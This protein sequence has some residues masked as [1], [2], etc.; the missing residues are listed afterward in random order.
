MA[1]A[2]TPPVASAPAWHYRWRRSGG[3][4]F[5]REQITTMTAPRRLSEHDMALQD[6]PEYSAVREAF[7][8][9]SWLARHVDQTVGSSTTR[10]K[11][12]LDREL[13]GLLDAMV[14]ASPTFEI[15]PPTF[16]SGVQSLGARLMSREVE[17]TAGVVL[18]G[19]ALQASLDLDAGLQARQLTEDEMSFLLDLGLVPGHAQSGGWNVREV[20]QF[21]LCE[22]H[23]EGKIFGHEPVTPPPRRD[24]DDC[25]RRL[26]TALRLVVGGCVDQGAVFSIHDPWRSPPT[27]GSFTNRRL[28]AG[29]GRPS[30]IGPGHVSGVVGYYRLLD[31]PA[32]R[33]PRSLGL[34]L[35]RFAD[36]PLRPYAEDALIDLMI[37]ADGLFSGSKEFG[38]KKRVARHA[39]ERCTLTDASPEEVYE[40]MIHAYNARSELVHGSGQELTLRDIHGQEATIDQVVDDLERIVQLGLLK[41]IEK[42]AGM[43]P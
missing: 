12:D 34:L 4:Y 20:D 14:A 9:D 26:R 22:R 21:A 28:V 30:V 35:R 10:S 19:L 31:H 33:K 39:S 37:A 8:A 7:L 25:A 29:G 41:A 18:S 38:I 13:D 36:S 1:A 16:D 40:F 2:G 27:S 42:H 17:A 11:L 23:V 3:A 15:D 6:M 5:W 24:L 32:V 43:R